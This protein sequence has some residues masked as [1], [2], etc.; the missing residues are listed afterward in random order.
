[1]AMEVTNTLRTDIDGGFLVD[2]DGKL[3]LCE[4]SEVPKLEKIDFQK[5][6]SKFN[7]NNLWVNLRSLKQILESGDMIDQVIAQVHIFCCHAISIQ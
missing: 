1:M 2:Q 7:T 6:F 3:R 4:L 5:K